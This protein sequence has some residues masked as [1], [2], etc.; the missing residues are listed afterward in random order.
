[1]RFRTDGSY[2]ISGGLGDLGLLVARWMV[3]RGAR[4][5]I[6]LGRTRLPPRANWRSVETGS[7][8][9]RQIIAIRDL[10]SLGACV[11]LASVDVADEG[12]LRGFLDEFRA[13]GWPSIRGVVHAAG[14]LQDGLLT[15]LDA[16]GLTSV[17]RPKVLGGWLLHRLLQDDCLDFFVLFSSAGAMLGQP[18]QGNYAAANAFLDALA[19]Y[20]QA[21]GLPALSINWGAWAGEGFAESV[22]GK[23][24]AARLALLGISSIAPRQALEILERLLGQTAHHVVAVPVNWKRYRE[25]YPG[26]SASPLLADL[27]RESDEVPE[28]AGHTSERRD[29]ILAAE[30]MERRRLLQSYLSEQ[31][32]RALGLSPSKL[33]LQQ[34]LSELGLDSLMAVELKNRIAVDLKVNVPVVKFLQG[35][36]VDQAVTQVLEQLAIEAVDLTLSPAPPVVPPGERQNAERLLAEL[37]QLSDEQVSAL[38]SDMLAEENAGSTR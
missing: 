11:H 35:L 24:L 3:E 14:V 16:A 34:S 31:V 5:L 8:L 21:Q 18:G 29:A 1:L 38:L 12:E 9:A 26:G 30:P 20:R 32:A 15:Q 7:H 22:G 17:L 37:D 6:L 10:E 25:F 36:S 28:A 4:R 27:A 33:D 19:H 23:R 2:L 13:E